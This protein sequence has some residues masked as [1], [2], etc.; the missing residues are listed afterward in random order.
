MG[1]ERLV[2]KGQRLWPAL[3]AFALSMAAQAVGA[4]EPPTAPV[5]SAGSYTVTYPHCTGCALD[6]LEERIGDTGAWRSVGSGSVSFT[7]KATGSYYYRVA[8]GYMNFDYAYYTVYSKATKVVVGTARLQTDSLDRQM[9]YRYAVRRGDVD[10]DGKTDLYVARSSE[11]TAGDGTIDRVILRQAG[12]GRFSLIVPTNAQAQQAAAWPATAIRALVKDVNADG[13]AD[14][15]LAG[16]A[17]AAGPGALDQIVFASGANSAPGIRALD[18]PF[19]SFA[20]DIAG[21]LRNSN[22]FLANADYVTVVQVYYRTVCTSGGEVDPLYYTQGCY[23]IPVTAVYVV[24]DFSRFDSRAIQVWNK[25]AAIDRKEID[26][27][28]GLDHIEATVEA[29]IAAQVGGWV[30]RDA[31]GAKVKSSRYRRGFELFTALLRVSEAGAAEETGLSRVNNDAVYVTGR[32]VI[33]F[34]PMHTALE[35]RG[36]TISAYDSIDGLFDDGTLISEVDWV[37]DRPLLTM[38]LGTL[39]GPVAPAQYWARLRAAD[40]RYGDNLPYDA[41][42]SIGAAGYNSNGYTHGIVR[43]THGASSVSLA[44]FVGGEKPVPSSVFN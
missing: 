32:R 43:A 30:Q 23:S 17:A 20:R 24:P 40:S 1:K 22:Y 7:S 3:A 5:S 14:V 35:Y 11:G 34:L 4:V 9:T 18:A 31:V 21:Y 38:K 2:A 28:A 29:V 19:R 25:E 33:G 41:L 6:W 26:A 42:P 44:S 37:R 12:G 16:V 27:T 15:A 13:F 8:Y 39:S 10:G 36:S